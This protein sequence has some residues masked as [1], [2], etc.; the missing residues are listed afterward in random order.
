MHRGA[1]L[2]AN[3]T[4]GHGE[5]LVERNFNKD[6]EQVKNNMMPSYQREQIIGSVSHSTKRQRK[7]VLPLKC[8]Q[9]HYLGG[10]IG[11]K[12]DS[13]ILSLRWKSPT[14]DKE[15]FSWCTRGKFG[16]IDGGGEGC[17]E[18]EV[19][20]LKEEN[21]Y[22]HNLVGLHKELEEAIK[23]NSNI[24]QTTFQN[25]LDFARWSCFILVWIFLEN[26]W[27]QRGKLGGGGSWI[28]L[29]IRL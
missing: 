22:E 24:M 11:R 21:S 2:V 25:A 26:N 4:T 17:L 13:G 1:S 15:R 8:C 6:K 16:Q 23:L 28:S 9:G 3:G 10:V 12:W 27:M 20:S 18:G 14:Q 5:V 29:R 7:I 19:W